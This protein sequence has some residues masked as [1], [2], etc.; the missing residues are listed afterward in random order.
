MSW[1]NYRGVSSTELSVTGD[2]HWKEI[3][4]TPK[5]DQCSCAQGVCWHCMCWAGPHWCLLNPV[6][7][8]AVGDFSAFWKALLSFG[9]LDLDFRLQVLDPSAGK[10]MYTKNFVWHLVCSMLLS[11]LT[12]IW[13]VCWVSEVLSL[14]LQHR[15]LQPYLERCQDETLFS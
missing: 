13:E 12:T 5:Q 11:I 8:L 6:V 3:Q 7:H 4:F 1:N 14:E 2:P 15:A 9:A 10:W